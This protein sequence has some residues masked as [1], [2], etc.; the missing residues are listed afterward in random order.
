V[1]WCVIFG[2]IW[3]SSSCRDH[4]CRSRS[5]CPDLSAVRNRDHRWR[6]IR[7]PNSRQSD[8]Y[9][10]A[11][12]QYL[13]QRKSCSIRNLI[14]WNRR[15]TIPRISWNPHANDESLDRASVTPCL[16]DRPRRR[17]HLRNQLLRSPLHEHTITQCRSLRPISNASLRSHGRDDRTFP[18]CPGTAGSRICRHGGEPTKRSPKPANVFSVGSSTS[19]KLRQDPHRVDAADSRTSSAHPLD[20]DHPLTAPVETA[21]RRERA[22]ASI[23]C[24]NRSTREIRAQVSQGTRAFRMR[25]RTNGYVGPGGPDSVGHLATSS[26]ADSAMQDV[27]RQD[28]PSARPRLR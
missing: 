4:L 20:C 16:D 7:H 3:K 17:Q 6:I 8:E 22:G 14:G 27:F 12:A 18:G 24:A 23:P 2:L 15:K 26:P 28:S 25:M 19:V 5:R 11:Y 21:V 9:R 10:A 13:E 1:V